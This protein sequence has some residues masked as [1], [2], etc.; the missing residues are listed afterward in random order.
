MRD[1]G[2]LEVSPG[3]VSQSDRILVS[4]PAGTGI[5]PHPEI[6]PE[7]GINLE[8]GFPGLFNADPNLVDLC[9]V[10][11]EGQ[12]AETNPLGFH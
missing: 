9:N 11:P 5:P 6:H 2:P 4:Q 1:K 10:D 8:T 7:P 3:V 12:R